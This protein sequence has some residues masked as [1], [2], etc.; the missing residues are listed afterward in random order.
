MTLYRY[1]GDFDDLFF[2]MADTK[3]E[4]LQKLHDRDA[5]VFGKKWVSKIQLGDIDE[6]QFDKDGVV[7]LDGS[8]PHCDAEF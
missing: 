4:A 7:E 8:C 1:K 3:E 2:M 6:I 5:R